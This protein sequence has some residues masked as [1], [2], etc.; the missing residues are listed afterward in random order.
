MIA[1]RIEVEVDAGRSTPELTGMIQM[2]RL[3]PDFGIQATTAPVEGRKG[4]IRVRFEGTEE[5]SAAT[6]EALRAL[7]ARHG[8][9]TRCLIRD[10]LPG[11]C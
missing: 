8:R 4:C 2:Y 11:T 7:L 1:L 10:A 3:N 5:I 6:A 9:V